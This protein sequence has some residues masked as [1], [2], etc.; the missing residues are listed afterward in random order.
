MCM[1]Y[2]LALPYQMP[3]EAYGLIHDQPLK[4][5]LVVEEL[6]HALAYYTGSPNS[7]ALSGA[8]VQFPNR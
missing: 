8:G 7:L 6:N 4:K 1:G 2:L 3:K 5:D